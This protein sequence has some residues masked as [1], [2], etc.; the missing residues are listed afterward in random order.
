[1]PKERPD[2]TV[3]DL[4]AL[5]QL[6]VSEF[7]DGS[8]A[9]VSSQQTGYVLFKNSPLP[10]DGVTVVAPLVGSPSAGAPG[11]AWVKEIIEEL[12]AAGDPIILSIENLTDLANVNV[13]PLLDGTLAY[14]KTVRDFYN[15]RKESGA[16]EDGITIVTPVPPPPTF[17]GARW[18]RL[19]LSSPDWL[20]QATWFIDPVAGNDE[21]DALTSGT[22]LKTHEELVRRIGDGVINIA[23]TVSLMNN[24]GPT[25]PVRVHFTVGSSG[26]LTYRGMLATTLHTGMFTAVSAAVPAANTALQLT[27]P[28]VSPANIVN[29]ATG[30]PKRIR[31]TSGAG[32]GAIGW[33]SKDLGGGT[34]RSCG[35]T[36]GSTSLAGILL[37]LFAGNVTP[38]AGDSYVV[39]TGFV[40]ISNFSVDITGSGV[41]PAFPPFVSRLLFVDID[42]LG[43]SPTSPTSRPTISVRQ[44]DAA[45]LAVRAVFSRCDVGRLEPMD[46]VDNVGLL[47]CKLSGL[48]ASI[49]TGSFAI[50]AC[51]ITQALA[52]E[53]GE[54][55]VILFDS[56]FAAGGSLTVVA[57][58]V[59]LF[60]MSVFDAPSD[61]ISVAGTILNVFGPPLFPTPVYGS[62]NAGVG[63]RAFSGGN[64]LYF[65]TKPTI[66][67]GGGD[68][69]IG[70][71]I[72]PYAGVPFFNVAN[73]ASVVVLT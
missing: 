34:Y 39:E 14:V 42:L 11:A 9:W 13:T 53:S 47:A 69:T 20:Q 27:D 5:A 60:Q 18:L 61:G 64:Y 22:A 71:V 54:A 50:I 55:S 17:P 48:S 32:T 56:Q 51:L 26:S 19:N 10:I 62:G 49:N 45:P 3:E 36:I 57:G 28:T 33:V 72:T 59:G 15:L 68:T 31:I 52:F 37:A 2:V 23:M 29:T 38:V 67:G 1:M 44:A 65:P 25:N 4:N 41:L 43:A 63:I 73:G 21:G 35:M 6:H 24:F 7:D 58:T 66:T 70:G 46:A 40:Q 8:E 12:A 16:T 30:G